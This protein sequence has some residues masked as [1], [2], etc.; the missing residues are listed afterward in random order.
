MVKEIKNLPGDEVTK[1][2]YIAMGFNVSIE[3]TAPLPSAVYIAELR[4]GMTVH[5]TL[6]PIAQEI[7]K[8]LKKI[9]PG[10]ALYIDEGPDEFSV[11][12]G[13]QDIVEKK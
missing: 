4:S 9:I 13:G 5:P 12:R 7:G 11:K 8:T 2:C 10:I 3:M 1:Q 6:R